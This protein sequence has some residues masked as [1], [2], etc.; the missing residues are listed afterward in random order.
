MSQCMIISNILYISGA[1]CICIIGNNL[2]ALIFY[3]YIEKKDWNRAIDHCKA[4]P[5]EAAITIYRKDAST[6]KLR[7]RQLPLHA[8]LIFKA[9]ESMISEL[10]KAY[11][12]GVYTQDDQGMLP[13]HLAFR[14]NADETVINLLLEAYPESVHMK[15]KKGRIP[16]SAAKIPK[17]NFGVGVKENRLRAYLLQYPLS[18]KR[19][20]TEEQTSICD[21]K[22]KALS[23]KHK[24]EIEVIKEEFKQ[25][26]NELKKDFEMETEK[27]AEKMGA[28]KKE[29]DHNILMLTEAKEKISLQDT[30]IKLSREENRKQ[31]LEFQS[32]LSKVDDLEIKLE[33][34][35][36]AKSDLESKHAEKLKNEQRAKDSIL[37]QLNIE[38]LKNSDLNASVTFLQDSNDGINASYE[39]RIYDLENRLKT[40]QE[41]FETKDAAYREEI[42]TLNEKV[43]KFAKVLRESNTH[44]N[45]K[46]EVISELTEASE[47]LVLRV[48]E[49]ESQASSEKDTCTTLK[50]KLTKS[51]ENEKLLMDR[52][53]EL[54]DNLVKRSVEKRNLLKTHDDDIQALIN[55]NMMLQRTLDDSKQNLSSRRETRSFHNRHSN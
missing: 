10:I 27:H 25:Q 31:K 16:I 49:I 32:R 13:C 51:L 40:S 33:L 55:E 15:D 36:K 14:C 41:S 44:M 43:S 50:Q 1:S 19:S 5:A 47:L 21:E 30:E 3:K 20:V 22:L 35:A 17:G 53:R 54:T 23:D 9:N 6:H 48:K 4:N 2:T 34:Q 12:Q 11:P 24:E 37:E 8:A 46:N 29:M 7:W 45:E 39:K 28:L 42:S 18:V 26:I 38:R 52:V